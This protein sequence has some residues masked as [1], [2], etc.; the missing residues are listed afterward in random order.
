MLLD[1][2]VFMPCRSIAFAQSV[3]RSSQN[4]LVGAFPRHLSWYAAFDFPLLHIGVL[5]VQDAST[6]HMSLS[7]LDFSRY[8]CLILPQGGRPRGCVW[9]GQC[10]APGP[11]FPDAAR[12]APAEDRVPA[13]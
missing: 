10:G 1:A 8:L 12:G 3:W 2:D 5:G 4:S 9:V 13:G 7:C 6:F 11:V